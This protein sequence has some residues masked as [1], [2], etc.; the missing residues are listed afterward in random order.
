MHCDYHIPVLKNGEGVTRDFVRA[1][2]E[3]RVSEGGGGGDCGGSG[4][5]GGGGSGGVGGGGDANN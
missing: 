2:S 3:D 4:D 5:C 1:R